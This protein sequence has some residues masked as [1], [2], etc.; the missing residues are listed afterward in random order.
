MF[1]IALEFQSFKSP[2]N[3]LNCIWCIKKLYS[4]EYDKIGKCEN[5][6]FGD[7]LK[8]VSFFKMKHWICKKFWLF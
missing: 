4:L 3:G 1:Q 7:Y 8:K 6:I 5:S 2:L